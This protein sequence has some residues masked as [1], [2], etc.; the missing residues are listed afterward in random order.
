MKAKLNFLRPL[1][2]SATKTFSFENGKWELADGYRAGKMFDGFSYEVQ[3]IEAAFERL[4]QASTLPVFMIHGDFVP[5][6]NLRGIRRLKREKVDSQGRKWE[7]T[8]CDRELRFVCFDIDGYSTDATGEDAIELFLQEMPEPF[9][10]ADYIY[11]YS[12]SYGLFPDEKTLKAHLF[13]WLEETASIE[14]LRKWV[15]AYNEEKG[16]GKVIDPQVF[17]STQPIYTQRRVCLNAPDPVA[18]WGGLIKKTGVLGWKPP[19]IR[20][21]RA[22]VSKTSPE[23]SPVS[24]SGYSFEESV[25]RIVNAEAWHEEI[26]K[27]ALSLMGKG[28]A[29]AEIKATIR[30]LM[31]AAKENTRPEDLKVWQDRYDDIDRSVEGAFSLVNNPNQEDLLEWL[32]SAPVQRVLKEFPAK[33]FRKNDEELTDII[34]KILSRDDLPK[35]TGKRELKNRVKG[36]RDKSEKEARGGKR[37]ELFLDRQRRKIFEVTVNK[38]NFMEAADR[39]AGILSNSA[40]WPPV[41][42]YGSSLVYVDFAGLITIRQMTKQAESKKAGNKSCRM[43]VMVP[44]KK[45]YHDLIARMGKD[46]RFVKHDLGPEITCPEKLASVV[47][48]GVNKKH[49]EL[50]GVVQSPFV[51]SEWNVFSRRGYD[52]NTG[53]YSLIEDK[54]PKRLMDPG[55]AWGYLKNDVLAEFPFKSDLDAAVM[56][57]AMMALL[58]RPVLA[59]DAAGMP[60]FGITAPVQSSGKTTLVNLVTTAILKTTIPASNFSD[61]EE[62]LGKHLL[63]VLREGHS[64]VLFDNI[65]QGTEVKSDVLAKA[66]SSEVYSGRLLGENRTVSV[67]ASALWFFTGNNILFSG[68]FSTRIYPVN[69]NPQ[70]ENPDTRFFERE[71]IL[72]WVLENRKNILWSL[73][74]IIKAGKELAPMKTSSRFKI[75]DKFIRNP[76]YH[77]SGI[78]I[79]N[80]ILSN[81]ESDMDFVNKKRLIGE[82]NKVFEF[83]YFTSRNVILKGFPDED[84]SKTTL[85]GEILEDI[86]GKY[87]KSAKSLGKLLSKMKGR[88]YGKLV[89]S[90]EDTDRAY[91]KI[92][93]I[94]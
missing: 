45:P 24:S 33:T 66:M 6:I 7:P 63:A 15:I 48:L 86:L 65:A 39:V 9:W 78:D 20:K 51:D 71:N 38:H 59:Q 19:E 68:D 57:S 3:D 79:N 74:S 26:N 43:P 34:E 92:K 40:R 47:S 28:V 35:G 49:R 55:A 42:F 61:D 10:E 80:A 2:G 16:W 36:F 64:C 76:L 30:G 90:R 22:I 32:V 60:G 83:D 53:L 44:F 21:S 17:V 8:I 89:L 50:T 77:A 81:K 46:I 13:F 23:T 87:A 41:F 18:V 11:Q 67:A 75:W 52:V 84:D 29:A 54:E 73:V 85:I 82:L 62:E 93:Q 27:L 56:V 94:P 1:R 37:K 4:K 91:W 70:M 69:L 58:E 14:S 31:L 25:K 72:D 5:G 12:A 88:A